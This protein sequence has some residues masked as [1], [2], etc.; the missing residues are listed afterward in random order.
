MEAA[1]GS[2][3]HKFFKAWFMMACMIELA[4]TPVWFH[5]KDMVID[6]MSALVVS[7]LALFT[8]RY[9]RLSRSRSYVFLSAGFALIA[10]AF[11]AKVLANFTLYY[12]E[13]GTTQFGDFLLTYTQVQSSNLLLI[14]GFFLYKLFTLLGVY[15]LYYVYQQRQ[16]ATTELLFAYLIVVSALF[17]TFAYALFHLTALLL[18]FLVVKAYFSRYRIS[19]NHLTLMLAASFAVIASSQFIFLLVAAGRW[20]YV[21]AEGVQLIGYLLLLVTFAG[22]LVRGKK[23]G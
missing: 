23:A 16:S 6:V 10:L 5:G 11:L 18:L 4:Y 15:L 19:R 8:F 14:A 21:F 20:F 1:S 13:T 22:V 7:L 2:L 17:S 12:T 3:I 9:Y